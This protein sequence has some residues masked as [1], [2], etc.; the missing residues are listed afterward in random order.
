MKAAL[1]PLSIALALTWGASGS[2]LAQSTTLKLGGL[3]LDPRASTST[4]SGPFTPVDALSLKFPSQTTLYLSAARDINEHW[5]AELALSAPTL[6]MTLVVLK[7]AALSG[8]TAALDGAVV[9]KVRQ[10]SPTLFVNYK[11]GDSS[12]PF[13]P[14]VGL[15]VNYTFFDNA[16]STGAYDSVNGGPTSLKLDDSLGLALQLGVTAKLGGPWSITGSWSTAQVKTKLTTNTLGLQRT[17]DITFRPSVFII[18]AGY[19]F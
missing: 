3:W 2:A 8:S 6:D 14:F 19:S 11:L 1:L 15:G 13:R 18:S 10:V 12:N 4:L 7:P 9:A 5:E 16:D 17:M